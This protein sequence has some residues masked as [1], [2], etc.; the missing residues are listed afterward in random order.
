[1]EYALTGEAR[2]V[3]VSSWRLLEAL[4]RL[5][6]GAGAA[7]YLRY[8][9]ALPGCR[10]DEGQA[11]KYVIAVHEIL[12]SDGD[13]VRGLFGP[14]ETE[15]EANRAFDEFLFHPGWYAII[16]TRNFYF[17]VYP[18]NEP[19]DEPSWTVLL[20]AIAQEVADNA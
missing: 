16:E 7:V 19:G 15:E 2:L 1:M 11:M 10:R 4:V 17:E 3:S 8:Q 13:E 14:Y 12:G 5:D 20:D 18:V 9:A 6:L